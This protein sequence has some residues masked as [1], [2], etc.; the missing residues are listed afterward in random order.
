LHYPSRTVRTVAEPTGT[1][2]RQRSIHPPVR[3]ASTS[4]GRRDPRGVV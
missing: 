3:R 1:V 2:K 4:R